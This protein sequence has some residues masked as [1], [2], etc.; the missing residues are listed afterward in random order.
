MTNGL[1]MILF[2]FA[3]LWAGVMQIAPEMKKSGYKG[4]ATLIIVS[5]IIIWLATFSAGMRMMER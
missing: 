5:S 3:V 2:G 4:T 1:F